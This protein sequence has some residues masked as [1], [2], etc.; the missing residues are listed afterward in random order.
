MNLCN[1]LSMDP[2]QVKAEEAAKAQS[3]NRSK[4][5]LAFDIFVFILGMAWAF[6]F[7]TDDLHWHPA[8]ASVFSPFG[9]GVLVLLV[10]SGISF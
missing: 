5:S 9:G 3:P 7:I 4:L 1:G 8:I 2:N 10:K 6:Y